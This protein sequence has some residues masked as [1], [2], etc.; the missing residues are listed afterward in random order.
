MS[1]LAN[2]HSGALKNA[3]AVGAPINFLMAHCA[4]P[5]MSGLAP[6]HAVRTD[7]DWVEPVSAVKCGDHSVGQQ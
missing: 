2:T 1:S 5:L 4:I 3:R 6:M 7:D